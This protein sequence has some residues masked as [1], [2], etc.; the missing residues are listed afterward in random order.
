MCSNR[1]TQVL[2]CGFPV[3]KN[4]ITLCH[5]EWGGA[6][7]PHLEVPWTCYS[8]SSWFEWGMGFFLRYPLSGQCNRA[9]RSNNPWVSKSWEP[10]LTGEAGEAGGR[11]KSCRLSGL[12]EMCTQPSSAFLPVLKLFVA[13]IQHFGSPIMHSWSV[14]SF[15]CYSPLVWSEPSN[16]KS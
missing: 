14:F 1:H 10:T 7:R 4:Q 15:I 8:M 3:R 2:G 5:R 16:L 9:H 6:E 13:L 12:R 11:P